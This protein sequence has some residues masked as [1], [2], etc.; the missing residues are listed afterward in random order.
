MHL[1]PVHTCEQQ[2]LPEV[3]NWPRTVQVGGVGGGGVGGEG[4]TGPGQVDP[5]TT[6]PVLVAVLSVK[7]DS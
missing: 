1:L 7:S 3:H 5:A 6:M 2:S 4:A